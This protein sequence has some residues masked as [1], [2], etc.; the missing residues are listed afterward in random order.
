MVGQIL[1]KRAFMIYFAAWLLLFTVA[2]GPKSTMNL[3]GGFSPQESRG[4][5]TLGI[6][7]WNL[8][9]LPPVSVSILF[10]DIEM[11]RLRTYTMIRAGNI[12]TWFRPRFMSIAVA[13]LIYLLLFTGLTEICVGVGDYKSNGFLLFLVLFFLHGF[14]MSIISSALCTQSEG[15][16]MSVIFY[17][18]VE[19][20]MVV[21]G[22]VFP[23]A[24]TYLPPY[25]G[26]I[27]QVKSAYDGAILYPFFIAVFS[28]VTIVVSSVFI[29]KCL[30]A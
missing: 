9:V 16:R 7:R 13:N 15:I 8:C 28:V 1:D 14:L 18:A 20:V 3:L 2:P 23:P 5:N 26:M 24:A 4:L 21:I 12:N 29:I 22:N 19:G 11:G 25:W 27:Q 17:L 6:V 30:R 10:M